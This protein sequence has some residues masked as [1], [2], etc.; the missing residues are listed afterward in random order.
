MVDAPGIAVTFEPAADWRVE[1]PLA[2][3]VLDVVTRV[4][5]GDPAIRPARIVVEEAPAEHMGLGVGTQLSLAVARGL[6]E[7][8]EL[9]V[10]AIGALAARC[11]RGLRSG[12]GLHGFER[13]GLIVDGGRRQPGGVPPL[14]AHHDFP[15][16]WAVLVVMPRRFQGLHG[17]EE[18]EAFSHLPPIP[19]ELTDQLC[20]LVLLGLLPALLENDL[21]TFG[22]ALSTLQRQ[23]GRCFAPAQGGIFAHPELAEMVQGLEAQGLHGVGQSSWG[24]ALYGFSAEPADARAAI[25]QNVRERFRLGSDSAFWTRA[26][27]HGAVIERRPR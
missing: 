19:E 23:V 25:L 2:A 3:R 6:F 8:S 5:E 27:R 9:P 15:P 11:G 24:P 1:G 4:S 14:L 12:I 21:E 16:E 18:S 7:L 26:S 17:R 10:P 20:R 13:G 22:T